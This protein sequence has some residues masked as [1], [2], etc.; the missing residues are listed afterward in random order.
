MLY[1]HD[2]RLGDD[3]SCV[4]FTPFRSAGAQNLGVEAELVELDPAA[5]VVEVM[6][7]WRARARKAS[8]VFPVV[9]GLIANTMPVGCLGTSWKDR[10]VGKHTL[11]TV[12]HLFTIKPKWF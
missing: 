12:S 5:V 11:S 9:G 10:D 7:D 2:K 1:K 3:I 6:L 8:K 4:K